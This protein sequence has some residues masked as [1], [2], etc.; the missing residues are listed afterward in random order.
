MKYYLY[1]TK[2][3]SF[4]FLLQIIILITLVYKSVAQQGTNCQNAY[5]LNLPFSLTGI[6]SCGNGN[7]YTGQNGCLPIVAIN[8]YAGEDVFFTFTPAENGFITLQLF[9]VIGSGTIRPRL[10]LF[11][12]C[13]GGGGICV[14]ALEGNTNPNGATV[15]LS[16]FAGIT[17]YIVVDAAMN[18]SPNSASCFSFNLLGS[19]QQV[20]TE[21]GCTNMDFSSGDFSGWTGTFGRAVTSPA[22]SP[23]ANYQILGVG[24]VNN[25]HTIMADGIDPC[26][27]FPRVDPLGAPYSLRLGNSGTGSQG[28]QLTQTFVVTQE[29]SSLTY[30]YAVVFQDPNHQPN[31]QPFFRAIVKDQLGNVVPC[32]DFVVS[33]AGNLPGFFNSTSCNNV[34]YKPWS[35]VN[36]DLSMFAGQNVTVEFTTGDCT[37]SGHYGY[38]YVDAFCSPST[39][40]ALG[41]TICIGESVSMAAPDGYSSYLWMPMND[42]SQ[43]ITITPDESLIVT[44]ELTAFNGCVSTFEI[45]IIVTNY[46]DVSFTYE[47]DNCDFPVQFTETGQVNVGSL[48]SEWNFGNIAIPTTA[49][50]NTASSLFPGPGTYPVKL[51][52]TTAGGCVDST[53]QNITVPTCFFQIRM[54]GD[55]LCANECHT[56][57]VTKHHGIAPFQYLWSTGE[58]DSTITVCPTETTIYTLTVTDSFGD[59]YTD[60]AQI[61]ISPNA[62]FQVT[63]QNIS[64]NGLTDGSILPNPIGFG[65]FQ[66]LWSNDSTSI[67][68]NN[69]SAGNYQLSLTDNFGCVINESFIIT[70]PDTIDANVL[71]IEPTCNTNTGSIEI[72]NVTGGT[73]G[74]SYGLNNGIFNTSTAFE[75]LTE[76]NYT[77]VIRDTNGCLKQL[78][79]A[80]FNST[81]PQAIIL[82]FENAQ[83]NAA[84]GSISIL[85][86][87]GGLAPY[88][89]SIQNEPETIINSFPVLLENLEGANYTVRITDA[90]NCF[91]DSTISLIQTGAPEQILVQTEPTS[92]G[93]SNG[94]ITVNLIGGF[95]PIT[96]SLN[97]ENYVANNSFLNLAPGV[98]NVKAMDNNGC[99]LE[100]TVEI[101]DSDALNLV[102]AVIAEIVCHDDYSGSL[103]AI[104]S[105]GTAP[106]YY[107]WNIDEESEVLNNLPAGDYSVTMFDDAGCQLVASTSILNPAPIIVE[108][109]GPEFVCAGESVSYAADISGAQGGF[110]IDWMN[111]FSNL[112]NISFT[113]DASMLISVEVTDSQGCSAIDELSL[114]RR[115]LP[116]A[117]IATDINAGCMPICVNYELNINS[118][119]PLA[120]IVWES[121]TGFN[122]EENFLKLCYEESG[123]FG[124]N[125]QLLDIHGCQNTVDGSNLINVYPLPTA[126]F[127]VNPQE[128]SIL[129]P[130]IQLFQQSTDADFYTWNFGDGNLS[131]E[132]E[133][134]HTYQDTGKFNICLEVYTLFNC[135]DSLCTPI[136]IAPFPTIY[137][138]NIFTPNKDGLNDEFKLYATFAIEYRLEIYNR[139][140][141]LIFVSNAADKGWDGTIN[142][143]LAQSDTYVWKAEITNTLR[144]SKVLLGRVSLI[145]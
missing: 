23:I 108:I 68:I 95:A 14:N 52:Q 13:P 72:I 9:N 63:V 47:P 10:F 6:N 90:N 73:P 15:I 86:I 46:P 40:N 136:K 35:T 74:F 139:W 27:G 143:K 126:M 45:P 77:I 79:V 50:G 60:T 121:S 31:Q 85:G 102:I 29:N 43:S 28:E 117:T 71:V 11:Q 22:G 106:Y 49:T 53:T 65:P 82:D 59:S 124:V 19:F 97:N 44:L 122:Y 75:N 133:P 145:R 4:Y 69:L 100:D 37:Q 1:K 51:I 96:Y 132:F 120:S 104:G 3:E 119:E 58:T 138:P 81:T 88:R 21:S 38:A 101:E 25:R 114:T 134:K 36:V 17:Y 24:I 92:C 98:Y 56:F 8:P 94:S 67:N 57:N 54:E 110:A 84:N 87:N 113:P 42:N 111:G 83:C 32:S 123:V 128:T 33:A 93:L 7:N 103:E 18:N 26:G 109:S 89:Y 12:G 140:G 125:V 99:I 115:P 66:V 80:L 127:T 55:T 16:V 135:R 116:E 131:E 30:R 118:T 129:E 112:Q 91:I 5:N 34:R 76:G 107:E 141:E 130:E 64:C 61:T 41:D 62:T 105:G 144:E 142:G 2:K 137:A 39:L 78:P 48:S 20:P 70:E